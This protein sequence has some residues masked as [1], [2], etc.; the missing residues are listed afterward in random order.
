[1]KCP[2]CGSDNVTH[3][4]RRGLEK[5]FR[6]IDPRAPYR[7]KDCWG[8]FRVFEAPVRILRSVLIACV[9]I[10]IV[11]LLI[12]VPFLLPDRTPSE[13]R[14]A[15]MAD[16]PVR[17][18]A[19]RVTEIPPPATVPETEIPESPVASAESGDADHVSEAAVP[20]DETP[21]SPAPETSTAEL[22]APESGAV[23]TGG[24]PSD[25]PVVAEA[26]QEAVITDAGKD[27]ARPA[28]DVPKP[29]AD[30]PAE[31][32][33]AP[34]PAV[35]PEKARSAQAGESPRRL[36]KIKV[37]VSDG[38]FRMLLIADGPVREYKTLYIKAPPR[39][40]VDLKGKWKYQGASAVST[41]G[42][43]VRQIRVG[44][45]PDFIRVVMDLRMNVPSVRSLEETTRGLLVEIE[46]KRE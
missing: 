2:I 35:V 11:A 20:Q 34:S 7:C 10:S 29:A 16:R 42:D 15:E 25:A 23:H 13:E 31:K 22:P 45:H 4:H 33:A 12:A 17:R 39:F 19:K 36:R 21:V 41:D 3:S 1:M 37:R 46:R 14:Q 24:P 38:E 44:E 28:Q 18:P 30:F 40:V 8:R 5:F 32:Q 26:E 27:V 6:F 43:M 9:A